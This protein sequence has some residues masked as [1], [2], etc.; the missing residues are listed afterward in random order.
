MLNGS[1]VF[2]HGEVIYGEINEVDKNKSVFNEFLDN[3]LTIPINFV[4]LPIDS[5][6]SPRKSNFQEEFKHKL[7][8][9]FKLLQA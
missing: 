2:E 6:Y 4:I 3:S 7:A 9:K 1:V 5:K 8:T